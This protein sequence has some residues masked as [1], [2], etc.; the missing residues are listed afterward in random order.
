MNAKIQSKVLVT[1]MLLQVSLTAICAGAE[2]SRKLVAN[3]DSYDSAELC[4]K[5][6][7]GRD[8]WTLLWATEFSD[9]AYPLTDGQKTNGVHELPFLRDCALYHSFGRNDPMDPKHA[10]WRTMAENVPGGAKS[11]VWKAFEANSKPWAPTFLMCWSKRSYHAQVGKID[12]DMDEYREIMKNH[13]NFLAFYT[14]DEW[15]GDWMNMRKRLKVWK[16][17]PERDELLARLYRFPDTRAGTLAGLKAHRDHQV[18]LYWGDEDRFGVLTSNCF[19]NHLV[20][21]WGAKYI[22]FETTNTTWG[23]CDYRWDVCGAFTRGTARQFDLPWC[24]YLATFYDGFTK[25][26]KQCGSTCVYGKPQTCENYY[27]GPTGGISESLLNRGTYFAYL[28]GANFVQLEMWK[29]QLMMVDEKKHAILSP[30]G[31]NFSSFHDFATANAGRRGTP[32]APVAILTAFGLGYHS[33][34]GE[35]LF[36]KHD[37]GYRPGDQ[38]T[39]GVFFTLVP[40]SP[41]LENVKRGIENCLHNTPYAVMHDVL[42]PD[43]PQPD[44]TF[45]KCLSA[46][47]VAVLTG[48][49]G[50]LATVWRRLGKYVDA[51]GTVLAPRA[52]VPS[53]MAEKLEDMKGEPVRDAS[54]M[55]LATMYGMGKGRVIVSKSQWM[56]PPLENAET[57]IAEIRRG[58]R[59]FPELDFFLS[60]FQDE[61]FPFKVSGSCLYGANKTADGW[62]LW[63]LNNEGVTKFTDSPEEIDEARASTINVALKAGGAKGARELVT[64]KAVDLKDGAFSWTIPA[65]GVAVF[66]VVLNK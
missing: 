26:G 39:D 6:I 43:A 7:M 53:A 42:V 30:R 13:P 12:L 63:A 19:V 57:A 41:R 22:C 44:E 48:P 4:P 52:N 59:K 47:P 34:G 66:E 54:G 18:E 35:T 20:A 40:G 15:V 46:Y 37:E 33:W 27:M 10:S 64:G 62:W 56:T 5:K 36:G 31:R 51:G 29:Q 1:L 38:M 14:L 45:L 11:K 2:K 25:E 61:L 28:N 3:P 60:R 58:T 50:D 23:D 49:Y 32:Y 65:G 17:Q 21:A 8:Y 24:W 55:E 9:P 16:T